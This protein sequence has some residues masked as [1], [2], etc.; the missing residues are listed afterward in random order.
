VDR[1]KKQILSILA[2]ANS[3]SRRRIDFQDAALPEFFKKIMELEKEGIIKISDGI[4]KLTNKGKKLAKKFVF[5]DYKCK[6]CNGTGYRMA[7]NVK[8]KYESIAK[9]RPKPIEKYDQGYVGINAILRKLAFMMERGDVYGKIFVAGDDDLFSIALA[10]T[11]LPE[12]VYPRRCSILIATVWR[13][14]FRAGPIIHSGR[15]SICWGSAGII[16]FWSIPMLI[17]VSI[18]ALSSQPI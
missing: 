5:I 8:K 9:N 15:R 6:L 11:G 13:F 14:W 12:K 4:V 17:V 16:W 18:C 10:L 7:Y 2:S 1:I 3:C